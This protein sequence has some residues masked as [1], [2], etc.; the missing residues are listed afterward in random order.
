MESGGLGS[1]G[2]GSH[3][4]QLRYWESSLISTFTAANDNSYPLKFPHG[5]VRNGVIKSTR[6]RETPAEI[7]G[8]EDR[9]LTIYFMSIL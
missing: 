8:L 7:F 4:M 2:F 9:K 6:T 1:L 5:D 3:G